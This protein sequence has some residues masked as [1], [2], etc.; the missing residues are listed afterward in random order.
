MTPRARPRRTIALLLLAGGLA[1]RDSD[2]Q[3]T[4]RVLRKRSAY[5]DLQMFSQVLN[6]IRI[7]HPDSLD[8]HDLIMAAIQGMVRSADPHS[9]VISAVRLDP[10]RES[11]LAANKLVPLP[12]TFE[13]VRGAPVVV[14]VASGSSAR[15][16]D[17]LPGDLL[18]AVEG[19]PVLAESVFELDIALSGSKGSFVELAFER[20]RGDGSRITLIRQV[21]RERVGEATA[22][23]AAVMLDPGTGYIKVTTFVG[24]KVADDLRSALERLE[25]RGMERLLL[26]LRDN[27]GGS[28]DEAARVAGEFLPAGQVVYT[29]GGRK[30][31]VVDTGRVKRGY[32]REQR[33]YPIVVMVNE[34]T[35]SAS[36]LVAGALQDHDRALIYGRPTFGK[37]LMMRGFPLTDGSVIV[38]VVGQVATPCGRVLQRQYRAIRRS[39]YYRLA[40]VD[41]DTAGRPSCR[42]DAGRTVFGG[43]G[44]YPDVLSAAAT[45]VPRWLEAAQ[46]KQVVL[47]WSGTYASEAHELTSLDGLV[48]N[49]ALS[50]E[51]LASFRTF[52]AKQGAPIPGGA[53]VDAVLRRV[54]LEAVAY[55]KWG[56]EGS[57]RLAAILDPEVGAA[58]QLLSRAATLTGTP[59]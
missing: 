48:A 18:V 26:D 19:Q 25:K 54:L 17:I 16:A 52:S 24:E 59:R 13:L 35:A 29:A 6:Q 28:I 41:R 2:A 36:E 47:T 11:Q 30:A 9:Y 33:R 1:A 56:E 57:Y 53:D 5:E 4:T 55:A 39:D 14:S 22:V 12:L 37:S 8:T 27:G 7:N 34:G 38:L 49:P 40:G 51:A 42:T 58:G 46:E 20:R 50:P 45:P 31:S 23:P 10:E 3:D 43:G 21:K 44:I 32:W 15:Q